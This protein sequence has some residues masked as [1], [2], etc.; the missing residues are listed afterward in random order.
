MD[1]KESPPRGN[2][3]SIYAQEDTIVAEIA[4]CTWDITW[5]EMTWPEYQAI[6]AMGTPEEKGKF[7]L[8]VEQQE[9]IAH[10]SVIAIN[11]EEVRWDKLDG[12]F[13]AKLQS[14]AVQTFLKGGPKNYSGASAT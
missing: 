4:G 9:K 12:P 3:E 6:L 11:G 1:E 13:G 14:W 7:T 8:K 5:R 2:V 10:A